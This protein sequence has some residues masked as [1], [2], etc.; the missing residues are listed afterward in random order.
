[1]LQDFKVTAFESKFTVI[2]NHTFS[3]QLTR[4]ASLLLNMIRGITFDTDDTSN[5]TP[6]S[7]CLYC[8]TCKAIY[9]TPSGS[10]KVIVIVNSK[11]LKRHSKAKRRAL[12]YSRALKVM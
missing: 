7:P 2:E 1:M 10:C 3:E 8:V 6:L 11:L 4:T 12:A 9:L 5:T